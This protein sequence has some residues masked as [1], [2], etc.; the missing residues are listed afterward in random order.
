MRWDDVSLGVLLAQEYERLKEEQAQRISTRDN[1]IYATLVSIAAVAVGTLQTEAIDLLLLLTPGCTILGWTYLVNDEKISAIGRY[2]RL[3]LA[4]R[5]AEVIET[6]PPVFGW[7]TFHR[8]D[9]RRRSRKR[10]QL[11]IDLMTFCAP[12]VI[13]IFVRCMSGTITITTAVIVTCE[14]T[15]TLFLARQIIVNADL[16]RDHHRSHVHADTAIPP[17]ADTDGRTSQAHT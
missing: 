7:E 11:V 6:H 3:D 10:W 16:S 2:I 13:A 5:L 15:M 1:L 14:I 17:V 12:G 8:S 9:D 4:R